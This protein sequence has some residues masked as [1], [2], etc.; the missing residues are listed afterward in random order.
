MVQHYN[1]TQTTYKLI[2]QS[3]N[4]YTLKYNHGCK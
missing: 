3:H 4:N 1:I 2:R